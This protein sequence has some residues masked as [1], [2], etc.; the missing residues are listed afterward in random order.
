MAYIDFPLCPLQ[1]TEGV[2]FKE[3]ITPVNVLDAAIAVAGPM[4]PGLTASTLG[5]LT[6]SGTPTHA[7][8][9]R[10]KVIEKRTKT[11]TIRV[12]PARARG[13]H[14]RSLRNW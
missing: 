7:G 14:P 5:G 4:P 9:Y 13:M 8:T 11:I 3:L 1:A 12:S 10:I 2:F 6:I